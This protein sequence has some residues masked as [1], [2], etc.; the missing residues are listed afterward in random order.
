MKE[1]WEEIAGKKFIDKHKLLKNQIKKA[2]QLCRQ[3][4]DNRNFIGHYRY[5]ALN[6]KKHKTFSL[7]SEAK[8]RIDKFDQTK[9]LEHIIDAINMLNIRFYCGVKN[10][11]KL[12]PID[13]GEHAARK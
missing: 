10:G 3:L 7:L 4:Q 8:K 1:R 12:E 11:E 2:F 13:D 6:P 5:G 9:N